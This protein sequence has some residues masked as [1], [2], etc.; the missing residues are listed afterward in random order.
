MPHDPSN[1]QL[2]SCSRCGTGNL[3][4]HDEIDGPELRC[5]QCGATFVAVQPAGKQLAAAS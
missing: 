1:L 2:P 3:M 4:M 5:L